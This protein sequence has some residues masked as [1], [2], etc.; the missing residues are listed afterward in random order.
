M[1]KEMYIAKSYLLQAYNI[2]RE[3]SLQNRNIRFYSSFD[4]EDAFADNIY[5]IRQ[6]ITELSEKRDKIID[7]LNSLGDPVYI[8]VLY[9]RFVENKNAVQTSIASGYSERTVYRLQRQG[10]KAFYDKF[11]R[12]DADV[13]DK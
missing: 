3:M 7:Q 13:R 10:L 12:G 4:T 5:K 1:N 9:F 6:R 11:L 2:G 8:R